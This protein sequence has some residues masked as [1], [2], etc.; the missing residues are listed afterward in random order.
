MTGE[1]PDQTEKDHKSLAMLLY[2]DAQQAENKLFEP[3]TNSL[4]IALLDDRLVLKYKG[5]IK[6]IED[7]PSF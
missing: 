2:T 4:T 7:T 5:E 1:L 3:D 6:V